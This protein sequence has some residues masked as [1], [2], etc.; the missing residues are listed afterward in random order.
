MALEEK[1]I[2]GIVTYNEKFWECASY[3]RLCASYQHSKKEETLQIFVFDNT[4]RK[5]WNLSL[6][7]MQNKNISVKYHRNEKN[8]GISFA[9]N[10]IAKY[11]KNKNINSLIF[12]DQDTE[13]PINF[14]KIYTEIA[15]NSTDLK[16]AVPKIYSKNGLMSPSKFVNYRSLPLK[17]IEENFLILENISCINSGLLVNTEFYFE[18]GG[19]NENLRLD[20]CDHEFMERVTK[21]IN[22]LHIIPIELIQDFSNDT[23]SEEKALA[24]YQL[25]Y[26]DMKIYRKNKKKILFFLSVDLPHLLKLS[27]NY[28]SLEFFKIRIN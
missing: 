9:Y 8:P 20:F 25:F 5:D 7:E 12:L 1:L 24:R 4:E 14:Y 22:K 17:K 10:T 23:N 16:I 11:A 3:Q 13:L 27:L 15:L 19:Y 28:K 6:P 21:K 26:R 18:C 2:F